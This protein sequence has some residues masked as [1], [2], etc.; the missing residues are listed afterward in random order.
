[1]DHSTGAMQKLNNRT[2]QDFLLAGPV[3]TPARLSRRN[4]PL[5]EGETTKQSA[6]ARKQAE[7]KNDKIS[8]K[9]RQWQLV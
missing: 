3:A 9:L 6:S 2:R 1:L 8:D 5:Q 4:L 7:K